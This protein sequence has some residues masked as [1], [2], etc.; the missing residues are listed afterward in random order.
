MGKLARNYIYNIIYQILV[1]VA[2]IVTAPY[3]ARV[4]GAELL[5]T[6]NYVVTVSGVFTTIG[7]LG[8]QNYAI[9]EIAYV[10]KDKSALE[11]CF[12]ELSATRMILLLL[13]MLLY[14]GYIYI[15]KY[16]QLM[17]IQIMY[18]IAVFV[19]PCW[20]Y[21]GMEDM[22]K[23]V[24]RNFFA[25][26]ANIIG[27]F[28]LVKTQQDYIKYVFLLS[29]MTF[30]ASILAVPHLWSYFDIRPS[31]VSL[32]AIRKH[33]KGSLELFWPQ[34]ATMIYLSVDK[35]MLEHF[36]SSSAVAFYDQAEKIVK[37]P[38]AFI[39]V[40]STVMM[41]RLASQFADDNT[42][43]VKRYLSQTILF[44]SMLAFPMMFG[45][46]GIAASL[47]PWYLGPE[48]IPVAQ[49]IWVLSPIVVLCSL[50]GISGDQYLVATNQTHV[51]TISYFVAAIANVLVDA[52]LIPQYGIVGAAIGTIVAYGISLIVQYKVLLKNIDLKGDM[53][54]S[55]RYFLK[56]IPMFV[57]V[58]VM[59]LKM[60]ATWT[61]TILQIGIGTVVYG[62]TLIFCKD[63]M[64]AMLLKKLQLLVLHE[65]T[66]NRRK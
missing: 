13:T 27:I 34:V 8:M 3:L 31:K 47:I 6:A 50:V 51:M 10:K 33:L 63:E 7:L 46:A 59:D 17:W 49:A 45:I 39:T 12:Y 22:G 56:A 4:L 66:A 35:I 44:S 62:M 29:F 32:H 21:I 42:V 36:V 30:L 9:R 60:P 54:K 25:K 1:L 41:P 58:A 48:F 28:I 15:S 65:K 37:I 16:P 57:V 19:D 55:G 64:L 24:A 38:L 40:L 23:A 26:V 11:K 20:F 5:G 14:V 53:F 18:V 61:T 43:Q 2:P 52:M